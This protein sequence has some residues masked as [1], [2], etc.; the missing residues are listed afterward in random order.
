MNLDEWNKAKEC[1]YYWDGSWRDIYVLDTTLDHWSKWI[2]LINEKYSVEFYNGQTQQVEPIIDKR[3]V[4]DYLK[5]ESDLLNSA[6]VEIGS[7]S[8]KCHFFTETEIEN[9]IDPR[10]VVTIED[11]N[12]LVEYFVD[13]SK[14]LNKEVVITAENQR[15]I[16]CM[17]VDKE[18]ISLK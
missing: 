10:E 7:V 18:V 8:V 3:A 9:D 1:V 15:D 14:L 5:G 2:D 11:H 16:I 13:M 6:T 17:S 12:R 4:F